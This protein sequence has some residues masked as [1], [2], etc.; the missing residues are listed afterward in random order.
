MNAYVRID[1]DTHSSSLGP[2]TGRALH[3]QRRILGGLALALGLAVAAPLTA[4][5]GFSPADMPVGQDPRDVVT[6]D[7]NWDG[8]DDLAVAN[9]SSNN[10]SIL[11]GYPGAVFAPACSVPVASGP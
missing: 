7:F 3:A 11:W 4:A 8:V 10:I 1:L 9:K 5:Q 2:G 6:A